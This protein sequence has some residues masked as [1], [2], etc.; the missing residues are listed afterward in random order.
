MKTTRPCLLAASVIAVLLSGCAAFNTVPLYREGAP[1]GA[2][3]EDRQACVRVARQCVLE[4]HARSGYDGEPAEMLYPSRGAYLGCM[5][6]RGYSP[7][8]N[9]YLPPVLVK[10]TDYRPGSDCFGG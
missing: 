5:A 6:T 7:V 4:R 8:F 10:M 3:L 9:G 1:Y 2:F